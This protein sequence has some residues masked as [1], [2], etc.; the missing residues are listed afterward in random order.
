MILI[1]RLDKLLISIINA[2]VNVELM[3]VNIWSRMAILTREDQ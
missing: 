1:R 2:L 3:T